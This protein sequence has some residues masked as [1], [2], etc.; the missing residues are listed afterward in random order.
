M[1]QTYER[2]INMKFRVRFVHEDGSEIN[3]DVFAPGD[4]GSIL[5]SLESGFGSEIVYM[6]DMPEMGFMFNRNENPNISIQRENNEFNIR[7]E[8]KVRYNDS[9][10]YDEFVDGDKDK[11]QSFIQSMNENMYEAPDGTYFRY[12]VD[13]IDVDMGV[14]DIVQAQ[15]QGGYKKHKSRRHR[16]RRNRRANQTRR[17]YNRKY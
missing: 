13:N 15:Q 6:F 2:K 14:E 9:F 12:A 1:P 7:I 11:I 3:P 8:Q 10:E 17:R 16:T 5:N 4:Q